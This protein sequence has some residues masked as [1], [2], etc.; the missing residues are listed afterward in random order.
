MSFARRRP[1]L[2]ALLGLMLAVLIF[3]GWM[4]ANARAMPVVRQAEISLPFPADAPRRPIRIALMTD[5]HLSGPDNSPERMARIVAQI[6]ALRPDLI[7]LGGDY[8][9]DDKGAAVYDAQASIAAFAGLRA[10][11]GVIAVLGNHDA[12]SRKNQPALKA[13]E[14]QQAFARVGVVLLQNRAIRRGPLVIGGVK[15]IYTR[16]PDMPGTLATM[17]RL[18]GVPILLSHSPD[19]FPMLPDMAALMLV[20]H[21]HCGQIAFPIVGATYI[22]SRYGLR[23][24]CGQYRDGQRHM[25]VSAGVG[26]SGLPF[27][28]F[29][30]PDIWIVTI[31]P[32]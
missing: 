7:L 22:P 17:R 9:G 8:I 21:T 1:W 32:A 31:R 16:K 27:R 2:T 6:D 20:G 18:G 12:H 11:L 10:P 15:D 30:P 26:T 5:T 13:S 23:Y 24:A 25:I 28:M 14:W 19:L 29:A 4:L 3:A